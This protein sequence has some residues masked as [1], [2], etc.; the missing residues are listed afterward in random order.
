VELFVWRP[1]HPTRAPRDLKPAIVLRAV[2]N[3]LASLVELPALLQ[4]NN[5]CSSA[6]THAANLNEWLTNHAADN[7]V[8]NIVT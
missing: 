4:Y 5:Y 6:S 7:K 1:K 8:P 2:Y 3:Y